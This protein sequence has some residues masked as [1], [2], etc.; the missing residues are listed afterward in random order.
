VENHIKCALEVKEVWYYQHVSFSF[1]K[2]IL[3]EG[4]V[5]LLT[6]SVKKKKI[7]FRSLTT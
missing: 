3:L 5:F 6:A 2:E 1:F 7:P 4:F